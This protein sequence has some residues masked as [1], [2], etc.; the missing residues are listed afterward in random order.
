VKK[1]TP[2]KMVHTTEKPCELAR[3]AMEYS[4]RPG[5]NV[6]DL[7]AGSGSTCI[8]AEQTGRKS[9]LMEIDPLYSDVICERF[10]AFAGKEP[11]HAATGMTFSEL[12]LKKG[13]GDG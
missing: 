2:Q 11:V 9:F 3:R 10:R 8:A 13:T 6:L 12:K 4:S 5:E 1:V 7:F